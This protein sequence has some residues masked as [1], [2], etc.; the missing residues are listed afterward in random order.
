MVDRQYEKKQQCALELLESL[1]PEDR[2][3]FTQLGVQFPQLL[4]EMLEKQGAISSD[5]ARDAAEY[6]RNKIG[7][8]DDLRDAVREDFNK[9]MLPTAKLDAAPNKGLAIG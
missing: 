8:D 1:S 3:K 6:L 5:D 2:Q 4:K 7:I 9:C